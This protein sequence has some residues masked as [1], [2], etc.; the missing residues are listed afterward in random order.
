MSACADGYKVTL[1][2]AKAFA[3]ADALAYCKQKHGS[4]STLVRGRP[5]VMA[6]GQRLVKA[7]NLVPAEGS[8]PWS[9]AAWTGITKRGGRWQDIAGVVTQIPWCPGEPNN[10][11]GS[12]GCA[13][14]LT[15]CSG[16]S[17]ALLNDY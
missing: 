14:L 6:A 15:H 9:A 17:S 3:R 4:A 7:A 1:H 16:G 8:N 13:A 11:Q 10:G 12:E 5:A 2:R